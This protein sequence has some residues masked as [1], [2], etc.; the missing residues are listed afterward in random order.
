MSLGRFVIH[1]KLKESIGSQEP[2]ALY[3][4]IY[5][6][7]RLNFVTVKIIIIIMIIKIIIYND[8]GYHYI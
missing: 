6:A 2:R 4:E 3:T 8:P 5:A 7:F 1:M